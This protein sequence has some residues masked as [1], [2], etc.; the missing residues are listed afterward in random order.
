[1]LADL[2]CPTK[3]T[4]YTSSKFFTSQASAKCLIMYVM[5]G[6]DVPKKEKT[7][8][9]FSAEVFQ[10]ERSS[11]KF[12]VSSNQEKTIHKVYELLS[13]TAQEIKD[14]MAHISLTNSV[15]ARLAAPI[16]STAKEELSGTL[17][18]A[19][20][21]MRFMDS[22]GIKNAIC[23]SEDNRFNLKG[24]CKGDVDLYICL[25][26]EKIRTHK[27]FIRLIIST[28]FAEMQRA[29]GEIIHHNLLML[30]DEMPSLGY[31]SCIEDA[32][33]YGRGYGVNMM[34]IS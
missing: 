14:L 31:M 18:T 22:E 7:F 29:R 16:L 33:I 27:K 11:S 20:Q 28:I 24:I 9:G 5:S 15:A 26:S 2:I 10:E 34:A 25:P 4:D 19:R 12:D 1:M 30:L 6:D 17:N 21:E 13:G 8:V 23:S 32:I 3:E